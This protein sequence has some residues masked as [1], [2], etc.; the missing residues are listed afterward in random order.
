MLVRSSNA[1]AHLTCGPTTVAKGSP[2]ARRWS[3]LSAELDRADAAGRTDV[4]QRS[5]RS[6]LAL[7]PRS[8]SWHWPGSSTRSI[9][10]A[11]ADRPRRGSRRASR[12]PAPPADTT[13]QEPAR[14]ASPPCPSHRRG[15]IIPGALRWASARRSRNHVVAVP[16]KFVELSLVRGAHPRGRTFLSAAS[17]LVRVRERLLRSRRRRAAPRRLRHRPARSRC[18]WCACSTGELPA[19][20]PGSARGT[21]PTS[22]RCCCCPATTS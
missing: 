12:R 16:G 22:S 8:L 11:E 9:V 15:A 7:D 5:R 21:S 10:D 2:D 14:I 13:V 20:T 18:A 1:C 6:G 17:G 4:G 19:S 3:P